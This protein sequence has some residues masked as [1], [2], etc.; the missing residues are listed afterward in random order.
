MPALFVTVSRV[1]LVASFF[2]TT[3]AFGMIASVLSATV[4]LMVPLAL[5]AKAHTWNAIK[6]VRNKPMA[7]TNVK[8]CVL[9]AVPIS[10]G[11]LFDTTLSSPQVEK[12]RPNFLLTRPNRAAR[13]RYA[14]LPHPSPGVRRGRYIV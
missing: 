4:A 11:E 3:F 5:C 7:A 9:Y 6:A 13:L 14:H 1:A 8:P 12:L 2:S 10:D